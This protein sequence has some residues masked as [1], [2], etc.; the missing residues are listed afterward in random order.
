[1]FDCIIIGA[2]P[3]GIVAVKELLENNIKNI[4]CL[5]QFEK[6]G[7]TF[8]NTYDN[9]TLTSSAIFS[10]FSDFWIGNNKKHTFWTKNEVVDYWSDYAKKFNV[11]ERIRFK[12]KVIKVESKIVFNSKKEYWEVRIESGEIFTC[13]RLILA[14]GN[15]RIS[16]YPAWKN[17]LTNV[18]FLHSKNYKNNS[19]FVDKR[20]L[21]V[22]GGE[23]GSDI[24]LEV[25]KVAEKCWV[26]LRNS[27]GWIVPRKRNGHAADISTHRGIWTLPAEFGKELSK[28]IQKKERSRN[29]PIFD[30][31]AELNDFIDPEYGI[32]GVYGTKTL[33]LPKAMAN[34]GCEIVREIITVEQ[35][36]KKIY[37][38]DG[39]ILENIDIIVFCTGYKNLVSFLPEEFQECDPRH[40]YKHMFNPKILDRIIW[41]GWARPSF[42]S[43][44]PIMEMQARLLALIISGKHQLPKLHEMEKISSLDRLYYLKI[45]K[46]NAY[47]IRSLVEYHRYMDDLAHL[48]GCDPPLIKYFFTKPKVW[49]KMVYG[50]TQA[51]QFRLKGPGKKTELAYEIL[52]KI[53]VSSF[54]FIVKQGIL[55]RIKYA[56]K[57]VIISI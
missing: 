41:M 16:K 2:G 31:V 17:K 32:R 28:K 51:T 27:T 26:S 12:S 54:N 42:G 3:S 14:I 6:L 44:F 10:M 52:R 53:P 5:D 38:S 19:C 40:M 39:K 50:P 49:F 48:I 47:R 8:S 34:H 56:L 9:L 55:G 24:A 23:S 20:V 35:G 57:K 13:K 21:V 11:T 45:F 36:G 30:A 1:M 18:S 22:G 4:L 37:T 46:G 7:G 29:S 33:A 25:S 43:Q 15:N